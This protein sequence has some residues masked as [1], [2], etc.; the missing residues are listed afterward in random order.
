MSPLYL[1]KYDDTTQVTLIIASLIE[2]GLIGWK[3]KAC[4][5]INARRRATSILVEEKKASRIPESRL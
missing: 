2:R 5:D 1:K 4:T 3:K